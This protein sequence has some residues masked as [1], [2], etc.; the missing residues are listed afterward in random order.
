[1]TKIN[2]FGLGLPS[3]SIKA[4]A[5]SI[6]NLYIENTEDW[7][8]V[9]YQMPGLDL[10]ASFGDTPIRGMYVIDNILYLIHYNNFYSITPSG[11]KKLIGSIN[12]YSGICEFAYNGTQIM[13]ATSGSVYLYI[14]TLN[15]FSVVYG[16]MLAG[17]DNIIFSNGYFIASKIKTMQFYVSDLYDGKTWNPLNFAS[18]EASPEN[19]ERITWN[20]NQLLLCGT[21][22]LEFWGI[23]DNALFPYAPQNVTLDY[24]LA[25]K[26][27]LVR[28]AGSVAF[29]AKNVLGELSIVVIEGY[30][31]K[32]ISNLDIET[33]LSRM[34]N[35]SDVQALSYNHE[36]HSFYIISF[37]SNNMTLCYD[38]V[39]GV[40][41]Y[42][43]SPNLDRFQ[44]REAVNWNNS[45]YISH[46]L[47][48]KLFKVNE[49]SVTEEGLPVTAEIVSNQILFDGSIGKVN[50]FQVECEGGVGN[51][52]T[53][54]P[55]ISLQVSRDGGY[56][57]S[58]EQY[59][60]LGA[61]GAYK[62]SCKWSRLGS[63]RG[64]R[65]KLKIMDAVKKA[66]ISAYIY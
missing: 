9:A 38:L 2:L 55:Q 14:P 21:S 4:N 34:G 36:G 59:Q 44:G 24:G 57:Y 41:S 17:C 53:S 60:P 7:G 56:T 30:T 37:P 64:M 28:Y 48:G 11:Y 32:K 58:A 35:V 26:Q 27:S 46:Y 8:N 3:K 18:A 25:A 5:N 20:N 29:L 66:I 45:I 61:L 52:S 62:T 40:W 31:P 16:E 15:E 39:S 10:F 22:S 43:K 63:A 65:F 50:A 12:T 51:Y 47:S 42:L 49:D 19:L 54:N 33:L 13:I 6:T 1:M 23:Q